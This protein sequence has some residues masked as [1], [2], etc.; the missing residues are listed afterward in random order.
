M[1]KNI[2]SVISLCFISAVQAESSHSSMNHGNMSHESMNH[3]DLSS[4]TTLKEAGTDP[5]AVIQE[6]ISALES[7]PNTNWEKVNLEALRLHL[8]EMQDITIN[9]NVAEKNVESGFEAIIMP[10]S[11]RALRA[12]GNVLQNHKSMLESETGWHM[13]VIKTEDVFNITVT[14]TD[15]NEIN[16]IRGLGYI[17]VMAY[18]NHHQ[19]HHW[20]LAS[21]ENPHATHLMKHK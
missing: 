13:E 18:G 9:V 10:I 6:V 17:G 7:N 8:V 15:V 5:F 20:A 2:I 3:G 14:T 19:P 1:I 16:K 11:R 12:V 21:G 4:K